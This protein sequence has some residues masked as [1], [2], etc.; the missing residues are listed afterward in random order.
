MPI[1]CYNSLNICHTD[2]DKIDAIEK[3]LENQEEWFSLIH[4]RPEQADWYEWNMENWGTKWEPQADDTE[5][6]RLE[7]NKITITFQTA[8]SPPIEL[9]KFM[10]ENEYTVKAMY[11]EESNTFIGRY[12]NGLDE[13]FEY[14]MD[15][16]ATI[17]AIPEELVEFGELM[18]LYEDYQEDHSDAETDEASDTDTE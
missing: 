16:L 2:K 11:H 3:A 10:E 15:D 8:S 4:P 7:D 5:Y 9:Y 17:E 1:W 6:E 13:C 18:E 12:S 14:D